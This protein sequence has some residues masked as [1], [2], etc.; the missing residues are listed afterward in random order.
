MS[1]QFGAVLWDAEAGAFRDRRCRHDD[2]DDDD[3]GCDAHAQ[4][5]NSLA[6]LAGIAPAGSARAD[7]VLAYLGGP[8]MR[9]AWGHAFYDAGGEALAGGAGFSQRVYPFVSYL[10]MAARFETGNGAAAAVDQLRRTY[11]CKSTFPVCF[12]YYPI[13]SRM[14]SRGNFSGYAFCAFSA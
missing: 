3:K 9:R 11:G 8:A 4:D 1:R 10:E 5:G 13:Q 12:F 6:V 2:D 7:A 14:D